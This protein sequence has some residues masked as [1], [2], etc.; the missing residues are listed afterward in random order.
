MTHIRARIRVRLLA[1]VECRD[2]TQ[3]AGRAPTM[4]VNVALDPYGRSSGTFAAHVAGTV[5]V[6]RGGPPSATFAATEPDGPPLNSFSANLE[7]RR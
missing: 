2:M 4:A 5:T 7:G 3:P 6:D 1:R